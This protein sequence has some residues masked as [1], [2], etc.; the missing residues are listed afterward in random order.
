MKKGLKFSLVA[1]LLLFCQM[2]PAAIGCQKT[3]NWFYPNTLP[4]Y[5]KCD[6]PC[7]QVSDRK[8]TCDKCGHYG[9]PNRGQIMQRV[10]ADMDVILQ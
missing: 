7:S 1:S 3:G 5:V 2:L 4:H 9:D 8:G 10:M 6:C